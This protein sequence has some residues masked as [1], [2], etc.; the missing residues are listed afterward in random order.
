MNEESKLE[1]LLQK[2]ADKAGTEEICNILGKMSENM[3]LTDMEEELNQK[4]SHYEDKNIY[5]LVVPVVV[6]IIFNVGSSSFQLLNY[7]TFLKYNCD[8]NDPSNLS[9][10]ELQQYLN[11]LELISQ[12]LSCE[13]LSE[14]GFSKDEDYE[15]KHCAYLLRTFGRDAI[16]FYRYN[17]FTE[18]FP[19]KCQ[20]CGNDSQSLDLRKSRIKH[21]KVLSNRLPA[22]TIILRANALEH[23]KMRTQL[24]QLFKLHGTY[25]CSHCGKDNIPI[26]AAADYILSESGKTPL[27]VKNIQTLDETLLDTYD[28]NQDSWWNKLV[29]YGDYV[30]QMYWD[31]EG[32]GSL[33]PYLQLM[34]IAVTVESI[35]GRGN[36]LHLV[37]ECKYALENTTETDEFLI[38]NAYLGLGHALSTDF[39]L[40]KEQLE[41]ALAH[42]EKAC[43]YFGACMSENSMILLLTK[44]HKN[45]IFGVLTGNFHPLQESTAE[46]SED[47][48]FT[49]EEITVLEDYM[50]AIMDK[51]SDER[52]YTRE[53]QIQLQ[54]IEEKIKEYGDS[55]TIVADSHGLM[56]ELYLRAGEGKK[57]LRHFEYALNI[58][59]ETLGN[60][61]LLPPLSFKPTH[62]G[63]KVAGT[64]GELF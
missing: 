39:D 8:I 49:P 5:F 15:I 14:Q 6:E 4:L 50:Y 60:E 59:T 17:Q 31:V 22:K 25:T 29:F 19:V 18:A 38:G 12:L 11:S 48:R 41:E 58:H 37:E 10:E 23:L 45:R 7:L 16:A 20:H 35:Y 1:E 46:M 47:S 62:K 26:K 53:I 27:S 63:Q 13:S 43:E 21:L 34:K 64:I 28:V 2:I 56:G 32:E 61:F 42:T 3:F 24:M 52:D 57:A 33:R 44:Q 40:P 30:A 51:Y 36:L 54:Q 9:L 55:S